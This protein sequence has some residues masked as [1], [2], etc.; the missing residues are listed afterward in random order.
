MREESRRKRGK[1]KEKVDAQLSFARPWLPPV[2]VK[3]HHSSHAFQLI[4]LFMFFFFVSTI[5]VSLSFCFSA[6]VKH[7]HPSHSFQLILSFCPFPLLLFVFL[8][9]VR[10]RAILFD[11]YFCVSFPFLLFVSDSATKQTILFYSYLIYNSCN[12]VF[13][14]ALRISTIKK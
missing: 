1:E 8:L 10:S 13:E 4:F 11:A 6:C 3:H 2:S 14:H 5:A 9:L 12:Q 7:H